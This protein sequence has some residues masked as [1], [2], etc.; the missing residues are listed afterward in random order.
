MTFGVTDQPTA[1]SDL[2]DDFLKAKL[3][4]DQDPEKNIQKICTLLE[5]YI[6][7]IFLPHNIENWEELFLDEDG[8]GMPECPADQVRLSKITY[9]KGQFIP[10]C[11]A[12]AIFSVPVTPEFLEQE[13]LQTWQDEHDYFFAGVMFGWEI[14]R[15]ENTEDLDFM[16]DGHM[17]CECI[18]NFEGSFQ[19]KPKILKKIM[20]T[21]AIIE[22]QADS[23]V[24]VQFATCANKPQELK[25]MLDACLKSQSW[26]KKARAIDAETKQLLDMSMK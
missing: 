9:Q 11:G 18:V 25:R 21:T 5:K 26:I 4:W 15:N 13:D 12:E 7:A 8:A 14:S 16:A 24:W 22:Y 20:S 6:K 23:G 17:G 3:L 1:I 10:N 2:P 19:S